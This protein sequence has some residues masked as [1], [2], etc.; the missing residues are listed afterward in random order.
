MA[1][2]FKCFSF[3]SKIIL[4]DDNESFLNSLNF[5]LSDNYSIGTYSNPYHALDEIALHY[6]ENLISTSHNFLS[7]IENEDD[8]IG[9]SVDFS[10]IVGLS[11]N[12]NRTN[13]ISVVVVDYSMPLM[14]GIEFCKK[15][16]HL[17]ILKIMLTGHADFRLAV[18]AFNNGVIDRFL[19]KD[20]PFMLE[21]IVNG[22]DAMQNLFF[23][24]LSYPLLTCFSSKKESHLL[25]KE[26][27]EH[28]KKIVCELNA[29]E[30]YL[31]NP[32]GSYLLV[33]G[34]GEKFYFMV[35]L[36]NQLD[37][38]IELAMDMGAQPDVVSKIIQKTHAPIFMDEMDYKLPVSDWERILYPIQQTHNYYYCV[39][40]G[41]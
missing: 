1:T 39:L 27:S 14:N 22:I 7:E 37:E 28:F 20:T 36:D 41:R 8:E 40:P 2:D 35:L 21:E 29:I 25:S 5:K 19:V 15:L 13:T 10:R 24:R 38:Y 33:C 4:I 30:F 34:N 6:H 26:Y 9:Y 3:K 12:A 31:L 16:S 17:P 11:E 23:E 18:D 32:L